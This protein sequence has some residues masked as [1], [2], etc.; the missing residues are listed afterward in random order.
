MENEVTYRGELWWSGG[1]VT[2]FSYVRILEV[3]CEFS[4]QFGLIL[5]KNKFD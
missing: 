1:I 4:S 2:S 3:D 5:F